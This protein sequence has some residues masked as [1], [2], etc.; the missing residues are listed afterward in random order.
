MN[1]G[2]FALVSI[3]FV[4]LISGI[5]IRRPRADTDYAYHDAALVLREG[6]DD[7]KRLRGAYK[8]SGSN[9]KIK[10]YDFVPLP[11]LLDLDCGQGKCWVSDHF[12]NDGQ[13]EFWV[14]RLKVVQPAWATQNDYPAFRAA[15]IRIFG[16][17]IPGYVVQES[18]P[19]LPVDPFDVLLV[20]H[21]AGI[22][23]GGWYQQTGP[24]GLSVFHIV[25]AKAAHVYARPEPL[26]PGQLHALG[27]AFARFALKAVH[28]A[29]DDFAGYHPVLQDRRYGKTY[30]GNA[31]VVSSDLRDCRID[32]NQGVN[33]DMN[34]DGPAA[35]QSWSVSC[36]SKGYENTPDDLVAAVAASI[37]SALPPGFARDGSD[38]DRVVWKDPQGAIDILLTARTNRPSDTHPHRA[39]VFVTVSHTDPR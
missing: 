17:L 36:S 19:N 15:V 16:P 7:F 39:V 13:P 18:K 32:F 34:L 33:R 35:P 23:V 28:A 5:S 2:R 21:Q 29:G 27:A 20:D 6:H 25:T 31:F 12:A 26:G 1:L 10:R 14:V 4:L 22:D 3:T 24:I 30:P 38:Q 9:D 37:Q 8:S 11:G